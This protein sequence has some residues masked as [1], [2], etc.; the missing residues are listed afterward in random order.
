MQD[1]CLS[2]TPPSQAPVARD[3]R[4]RAAPNHFMTHL[5]MQEA[6]EEGS[7]VTWGEH[8]TDKEYGAAP[9]S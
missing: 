2:R 6:D 5:A 3:P 1:A 4:R 7:P 9:A 8:V